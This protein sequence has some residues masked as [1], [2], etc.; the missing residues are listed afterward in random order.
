MELYV[1]CLVDTSTRV[2]N[3]LKSL[4]QLKIYGINRENTCSAITILWNDNGGTVLPKS[5]IVLELE[6]CYLQPS[7]FSKLLKNLPSLGTLCL[8]SCGSVEIPG[9][10]VSLHHLRMLKRLNIYRCDWISSIKGSEAL[11]SLEEMR[12]LQCYNLES[13]PDLSDMPFLQKLHLYNCPQVMRLSTASHHTEL[14]EV[15]VNSCDGLSSLEKLCDLVSLVRLS[16]TNCSDLSWLPDMRGF[17]S[18]RVL[19]IV[20]CPRLM[21]LPR[22]GLPVSLE[23]FSVSGC[24]QALEEQFQRKEGSDWNKFA[25]LPGCKLEIWSW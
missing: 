17:Y 4:K 1:N 6:R 25:A 5:L 15:V 19:E 9:M 14:K 10:P 13:V 8:R 24:H 23:T 3:N 11:L 20:G 18:L 7:S 16:V 22:G 2:F 21:S 12:I